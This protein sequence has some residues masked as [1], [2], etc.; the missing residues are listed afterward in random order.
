M[1]RTGITAVAARE[2]DWIRTDI[3]ALLLVLAMPLL[4]FTLLAGTFS[5]A[6]IRG[7]RIDVV[8]ADRSATSA[9]F[10]QA[11][12]AAPGVDVAMRSSDLNGAMYAIRS[13]AAIAAV[14][15][16]ENFE[17]DLLAGRRPQLVGLYNR[18]FF[19]PGNIAASGIQAAVA[20][21]AAALPR[22]ASSTRSFTPGSLVIEQYV[23]SNPALNYVQFL[24]RAVM[25]TVLHVMVAISGAFSVGSEFGRRRDVR[26]WMSVSGGRPLAAMI[27]KLAPYLGIFALMMAGGFGVLH[28]IFGIPFRGD[29][30]L[31]A[32]SAL[33]LVT[34]YL[35]LGALFV[36]LVRNLAVGLTLT[37][38]VCSP[39]FGFA[40]V[41]FPILGMGTF[42]RAWGA[43]L[44]LRWYVQ[45]LFD[46][47][48]RGVPA[49]YSLEPFLMLA[50]LAGALFCLA[51]LRARSVLRD[52]PPRP[53]PQPAIPI[54]GRPTVARAFSAEYGRVLR[55]SGAFG[56]IVIGPLLY[57]AL[58][59][60]PYVGQ[61]IRDIPV[62]V[63]D[64]DNSE[65]SR[66]IVEALDAHEATAVAAR[67]LNLV[68]AQEAIAR[69]EVF[70]VVSIPAG[71]E[72]DVLKG[73]PA[74]LPAFV[75]S[76]YFLLYNRA[77]Q[78][79][80]EATA[81]VSAELQVRTAR[82]DGSLYHAALARTSPVEYL[83]EP[84]FNPTGSYASYVVPAAFILILQQSLL[85]GVATLGGVTHAQGG[86]E[87]RRRRGRP[88]ALVG[89]TLAHLALA[90]PAYALYLVV[91]PRIYGYAA[92]RHVLD[93]LVLAVPFI[94]SVS[95]LGQFVGMLARRRETAVIMLISLGMP[96]FF[97]VGVAWPPEAI[98]PILRAA[99]AA[100][101]STF[102][103][104]ALV[105][106]N[107][108]GATIAD[109]W[110]DWMSLWVLVG[111]YGLLA[112]LVSASWT[113]GEGTR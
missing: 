10:I 43:M 72:R 78:G 113:R 2:V 62:A 9:E 96:L 11:I 37:G 48:A 95:L 15:I 63:V 16:P 58:Y 54:S 86:A 66:A 23:L 6:V 8:D 7:L 49:R 68:G 102:G 69:R 80:L 24:L 14:Y 59:P 20:S 101:P 22:P 82:P 55:D 103:I 50:G 111:V 3:V 45:I 73:Q 21:A 67:P 28:G 53:A 98:P 94:L 64:D 5:N 60:Q 19:T 83:S 44:P 41:G 106:V 88:A 29:P 84:L 93:L 27:G 89:Q 17:R 108:M 32:A 87:A 92:S 112:C 47:A 75:D 79:V 4:A 81:A 74:R 99:S 70:G 110:R 33:L 1:P 104:D 36:L 34:A 105:R 38:I 39:A 100:I 77:T 97:L 26:E 71:T 90:L 56:L 51:W 40:G 61:L 46:Q 42:G 12:S 25:P 109:V 35:S 30:I 107:Q 52:P 18:Q 31:V 85:M 13:G 91:L 76:A 57:A 65:M